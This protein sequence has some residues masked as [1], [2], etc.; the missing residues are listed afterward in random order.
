MDPASTQ[1]LVILGRTL[2]LAES[3]FSHVQ[4]S[5]HLSYLE[6]CCKIGEIIYVKY[7][8][9]QIGGVPEIAAF[10]QYK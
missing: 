6:S 8:M 3:P 2:H 9:H 10:V 4:R 1:V 7:L 5:N